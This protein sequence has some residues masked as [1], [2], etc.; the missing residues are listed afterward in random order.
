MAEET[1]RQ[2]ALAKAQRAADK[3][4]RAQ[5]PDEWNAHMTA[6]AKEQGIEWTPPQSA[7]DKAA[8]QIASILAKHPGLKDRF[9][10]DEIELDLSS[11]S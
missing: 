3:A 9:A 8:A 6:A 11:T 7:E 10:N 4:L 2:S 5:Y 1:N